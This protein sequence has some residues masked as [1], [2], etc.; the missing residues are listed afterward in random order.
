MKAILET[1]CWGQSVLSLKFCNKDTLQA[2]PLSW[3]SP[4]A[5]QSNWSGCLC[6]LRVPYP[7]TPSPRRVTILC[8]SSS[9]ARRCCFR[10]ECWT[11]FA[12]ESDGTSS[13]RQLSFL[14]LFRC[15]LAWWD[16]W[17]ERHW[18]DFR[19]SWSTYSSE[20]WNG[21]SP[22]Y[23]GKSILGLSEI[24]WLSFEIFPLGIQNPMYELLKHA[25][26][27]SITRTVDR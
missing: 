17:I 10:Q 2:N 3:K 7:S 24:D 1:I 23:T 27:N 26:F 11:I 6:V 15:F 22:I 13:H 21:S 19:M 5:F 18:S 16:L 14:V 12:V 9:K 8:S 25:P 20:I 4:W